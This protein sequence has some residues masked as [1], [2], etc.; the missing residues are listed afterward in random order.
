MESHTRYIDGK[1]FETAIGGHRIITDQPASGGGTDAGVT[2]LELLLASLG[3]C[4]AHYAIEYLRAR[5]LPLTGLEIRAYA[6][7]GTYPGR[8]ALF[9][10]E[11]DAGVMDEKHRRGLLRAVKGCIVHNTL[12]T[13]S[14]IEVEIA[15]PKPLQRTA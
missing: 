10:I 1:K 7:K 11:V 12:T 13:G 6:E 2:P 15:T 14:V 9:R 5:S 3:S 8:L 4:A